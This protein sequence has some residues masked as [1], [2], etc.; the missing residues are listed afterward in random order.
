[1]LQE[2]KRKLLWRCRRGMLEL[3]LILAPF[4]QN[5]IESLSEELQQRF[6]NLLKLD[7]P[8]LFGWLMGHEQV[9]QPEY[10]ELVSIIRSKTQ[11]T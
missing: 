11:S 3:D 6:V 2:E 10:I 9:D 7:D 8:V 1:M 5:K 4:V